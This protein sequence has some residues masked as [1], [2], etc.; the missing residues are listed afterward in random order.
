M[1]RGCDYEGAVQGR[2]GGDKTV[3]C[4]VNGAGPMKL[5]MR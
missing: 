5:Y 3:L 2:F 1:G 4:P